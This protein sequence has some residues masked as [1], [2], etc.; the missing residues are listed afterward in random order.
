MFLLRACANAWRRA[1][2]MSVVRWIARTALLPLDLVRLTRDCARSALF[3]LSPPHPLSGVS[4][5]LGCGTWGGAGGRTVCVA[6]GHY[7]NLFVFRALCPKA[8]AC[9]DELGAVCGDAGS[10]PRGRRVFAVLALLAI[11][12]SGVLLLAVRGVHAFVSHAPPQ[13]PSRPADPRRADAIASSVMLGADITP[14]ARERAKRYVESA[15]RFAGQGRYSEALIEYRNAT[16]EDPGNFDAQLGLGRCY[17]RLDSSLLALNAFTEAVRLD[18][19]S[20]EAR[21]ELARAA[22]AARDVGLA[23]PHA[24]EALRLDPRNPATRLLLSQCSRARY[25]YG[26]ASKWIEEAAKMDPGNLDTCVSAGD[27][28]LLREDF[29]GADYWFRRALDLDR[30]SPKARLGLA[31]VLRIQGK[32][33]EA[34]E[35]ANAVFQ[36]DSS[37]L[38]AA[39]EL[40][41]LSVARGRID[42]AILRYLKALEN[43]S[44]Q[45]LYRARLAELVFRSNRVN[46]AFL[47]ARGLLADDP[48][49]PPAHLVM[50]HLFF[51]QGFYELSAEHCMAALLRDQNNAGAFALHAR[52]LLATGRAAE[53]VKRL[54]AG[55]RLLPDALEMRVWLGVA[56]SDLKQFD[57]A[58]ETFRAAAER[59]PQAVLPRLHLGA[60]HERQGQFSLAEAAY[61]QALSINPDDMVAGNN[62]AML[63]L[64]R[65]GNT[66]RALDLAR[67]LS[68][69]YPDSAA[70]QD[71]LGWARF[72]RGEISEAIAELRLAIRMRSD[73]ALPRYH[74]GAALHAAG[75]RA[76]AEKELAKALDLASDFPGADDARKLLEEIKHA[77]TETSGQRVPQKKEGEAP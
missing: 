38:E 70:V 54:E 53:A 11:I 76:G 41:E 68:A 22:L 21:M 37:N 72:R 57:Q 14:Q 44:K 32:L 43:R 73:S 2:R 39:V 27:L 24:I 1:Q 26:E 66:T 52:V 51:K 30:K 74:L 36:Q 42:E 61:E 49:F 19:Q 55:L 10:Q 40:A 15:L 47:L 5:P 56:Y 33:V 71:T 34:E 4:H 31:K 67:R 63:L 62:L 64:E 28:C 45:S 23:E 12:W 50:A 46:D 69:R 13:A 16:T 9:A 75:D 58:A 25:D 35:V 77:A 18:A 29:A 8:M 17:S 7:A 59:H 60:L 48:G 65:K 6:A 3:N 20:P